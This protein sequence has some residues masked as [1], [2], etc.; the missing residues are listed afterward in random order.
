MGDFF[1]WLAQVTTATKLSLQQ[2]ET[3]GFFLNFKTTWWFNIVCAFATTWLLRLAMTLITFNS[4]FSTYVCVLKPLTNV[5]RVIE[6]PMGRLVNL[7]AQAQ[8]GL[9]QLSQ[10]GRAEAL[11]LWIGARFSKVP[12]LFGTISGDIILLV[13]SKRRRFEAQFHF[14]NT[15]KDQCCLQHMKRQHM[16]RPA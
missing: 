13:S 6:M 16:K 2:F 10:S 12:K 5:I 1:S 8:V 11:H 7:P 3:G 15:W 9:R 14:Y 4:G